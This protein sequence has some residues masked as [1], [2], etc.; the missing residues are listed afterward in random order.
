MLLL[1]GVAD[2]KKTEVKLM[3]VP[4]ENGRYIMQTANPEDGSGS[5]LWMKQQ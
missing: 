5:I 2:G 1:T 4:K 3:F